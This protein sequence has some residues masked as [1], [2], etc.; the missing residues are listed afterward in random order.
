MNSRIVTGVGNIYANEALFRSRIHPRRAAGR[1]SRQR[2]DTLAASIK[3]VLSD[4]IQLGGT[5][6]RDF[7]GT[8]GTP[9]YFAQELLVYDRAGKPCFQ[10]GAPIRQKVIGQRSSYYCLN[11]QT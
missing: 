10:C 3:H 8:G 6:L 9:G 11:C 2:L 7:S 4:A 5:T 1:I